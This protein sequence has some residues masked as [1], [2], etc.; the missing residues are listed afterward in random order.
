MKEAGRGQIRM[1]NF[2]FPQNSEV[3]ALTLLPQTQGSRLQLSSDCE[4]RHQPLL[5]GSSN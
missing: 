1:S 4:S 3:Q 5:S 2:I